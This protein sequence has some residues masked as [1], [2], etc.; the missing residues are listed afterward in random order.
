MARCNL[1][2]MTDGV[3]EGGEGGNNSHDNR[4]SGGGLEKK[5]KE[6]R[7]EGRKIVPTMLI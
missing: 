2:F 7:K 4:G 6:R 3:G 5:T 1:L